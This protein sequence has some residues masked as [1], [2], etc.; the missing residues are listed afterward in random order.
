MK[1]MI[2][3]K[4]AELL[5]LGELKGKMESV[6]EVLQ[7]ISK[8]MDDKATK[9]EVERK[10]DALQNR[11]ES[12]ES[13]LKTLSTTKEIKDNDKQRLAFLIKYFDKIIIV[14]AAILMVVTHIN[15]W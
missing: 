5:L 8:K 14:S 1:E 13:T 10:C 11:I 3:Q 2:D 9:E 4:S 6:Q 7:E 15:R 12:L